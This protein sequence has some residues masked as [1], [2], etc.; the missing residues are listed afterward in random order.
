MKIKTLTSLLMICACAMSFAQEAK[1]VRGGQTDQ[2]DQKP[3]V[4]AAGKGVA[5]ARNNIRAEFQFRFFPGR[6]PGAF[7]GDFSMSA[8]SREPHRAIK[9]NFGEVAEIRTD[10]DTAI[11]H[12]SARMA[13]RTDD[14]ERV[15]NGR[16]KITVKDIAPNRRDGEVDGN[17]AAPQEHD[18]KDRIT[19]E[20]QAVGADVTWTFEGVVARGGIIVNHRR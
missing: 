15:F 14:G 4:I 12:G 5:E 11:I 1:P 18:R 10:G 7:G 20:F 17:A 13:V 9:L 3:K 2:A 16:V 6:R 8:V 19:V